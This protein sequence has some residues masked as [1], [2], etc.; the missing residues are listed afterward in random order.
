MQSERVTFLTTPDHKAALD[1]F[2]ASQGKSIGHVVREATSEFISQPSPD[3]EAA[4][5]ALV[6]EVNSAVPKMSA[7]IE[8]II[9]TLDK[10]HSETDAFLRE[11]GVRK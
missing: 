2:A 9:A 4:L 7:S 8:R 5:A 10:T 6:A 11:M 3:D 1:A